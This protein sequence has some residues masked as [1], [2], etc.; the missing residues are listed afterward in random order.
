MASGR[1]IRRQPIRMTEEQRARD[2]QLWDFRSS[3][4]GLMLIR[5]FGAPIETA[6]LDIIFY[7]VRYMELAPYLQGIV[8]AEPDKA[9]VDRVSGKLGSDSLD[10]TTVLY[11]LISDSQ[12]YLVVATT[13]EIYENN[14]GF[15]DS[16][17]EKIVH[18]Q[19]GGVGT[20]VT[21][22]SVYE[23]RD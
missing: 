23:E 20:L 14:L 6:N 19:T 13:V 17:L 15:W 1:R 3:L 2:F 21:T 8:F 16:P 18:G 10:K 5:S 12:S 11:K 4:G 9:D 7:G 22:D